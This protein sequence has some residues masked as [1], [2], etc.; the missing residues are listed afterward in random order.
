MTEEQD[1]KSPQHYKA[2]PYMDMSKLA[3]FQSVRNFFMERTAWVY[4]G[5]ACWS[6]R[7]RIVRIHTD[8]V[9]YNFEV[10]R[11]DG[12]PQL[13]YCRALAETNVDF[14]IQARE[15]GIE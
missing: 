15:A 9:G 2:P 10:W 5:N 4:E 8:G 12:L 6:S 1:P 13:T 14:I 7:D 11:V 3:V